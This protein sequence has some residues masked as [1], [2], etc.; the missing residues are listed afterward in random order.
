MYDKGEVHRGIWMWVV[1]E[2]GAN[3][4]YRCE[5]RREQVVERARRGE[6]KVM[7]RGVKEFLCG[8]VQEE[9]AVVIMQGVVEN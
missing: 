1:K 8:C 4:V 6:K 2:M 9:E 3:Q 5:R 7:G